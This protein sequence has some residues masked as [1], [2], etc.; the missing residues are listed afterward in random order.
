MLAS[1]H[2]DVSRTHAPETFVTSTKASRKVNNFTPAAKRIF[3]GFKGYLKELI[4]YHLNTS[5]ASAE[6][7]TVCRLQSAIGWAVSEMEKD[8]SATISPAACD[9][10]I[11]E[12]RQG[13]TKSIGELRN[14][15]RCT[16]G[17]FVSR[18]D[19]SVCN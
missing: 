11:A 7:V 14:E 12:F 17:Q 18:Q 19:S 9:S 10:T 13:K 15:L 1:V 3:R 5:T 16:A 8:E 2:S 4:A 6:D